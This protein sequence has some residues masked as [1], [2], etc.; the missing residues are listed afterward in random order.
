MFSFQTGF[1]RRK[2]RDGTSDSI[3]LL[4]F[5][6]VVFGPNDVHLAAA[7]AAHN[8]WQKQDAALPRDARQ[9]SKVSPAVSNV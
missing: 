8:C 5:A 3:C 1:A 4:C 9:P 2:N 7:E 6:T